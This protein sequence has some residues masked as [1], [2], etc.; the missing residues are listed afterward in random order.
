[1]IAWASR[2]SALHPFLQPIMD[3]FRSVEAPDEAALACHTLSATEELTAL[4]EEWIDLAGRSCAGAF[5]SYDF[6]HAMAQVQAAARRRILVVTI[7]RDGRLVGAL[8]LAIG[9]QAGIR[10]ATFI[11]APYAQYDDALVDPA[12]PLVAHELMRAAAEKCRADVLILRRVRADGALAPV[13][14]SCETLEKDATSIIDLQGK[15]NIEAVIAGLSGKKR[16]ALRRGQRELEALGPIT[17]T[18][19]RG[20][21]ALPHARAAIAAKRQWI[22]D[23]GRVAPALSNPRILALLES[24]AERDCQDLVT[25]TLLLGDTPIAWEIGFV[26]DQAY[27]AFL[28][29]FNPQYAHA[30]PG[31]IQILHTVGWCIEQGMKSYD[32]LA[33]M[34]DYK[35]RWAS[36][37]VTVSDICVVMSLRGLVWSAIWRKRVRPLLRMAANAAGTT[38]RRWRQKPS[39]TE[40]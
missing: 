40:A 12:E 21:A 8:P 19:C 14:G 15:P 1:M 6:I 9:L 10:V 39:G 33:P 27:L 3:I 35:K 28:G 34:D 29:A 20:K 22:S 2:S 17:S 16:Q 37:L 36:H 32:L 30:G 23:S 5:Q 11:G 4:R 26:A 18:I 24:L 31:N 7:R 38:L 25:T 13:L